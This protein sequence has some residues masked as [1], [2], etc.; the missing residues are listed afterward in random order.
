L[1]LSGFSS[2]ASSSMAATLPAAMP[3]LPLGAISYAFPS[4]ISGLQKLASDQAPVDRKTFSVSSVPTTR[5]SSQPTSSSPSSASS[6]TLHHPNEALDG[7]EGG[8]RAVG[9]ATASVVPSK[10]RLNFRQRSGSLP[11]LSLPLMMMKATSAAQ[12]SPATSVATTTTTTPSFDA[13]SRSSSLSSSSSIS[14][15]GGGF[16]GLAGLGAMSEGGSGGGGQQQSTTTL[17]AEMSSRSTSESILDAIK[18]IT[19]STPRLTKSN[20]G[21]NNTTLAFNNH[22][23]HHSGSKRD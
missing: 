12:A 9:V 3:R 21:S 6:P 23:P 8:G 22:H 14:S 16:M 20:S 4:L 15:P 5:L 19:Q 7:G 1:S 11:R 18:T 17:L 2:F 13:W 10:G